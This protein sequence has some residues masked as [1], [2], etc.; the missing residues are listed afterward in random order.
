MYLSKLT[1]N[2]R[3]RTVR[4]DLADCHA[5][6]RMLLHA[7]GALPEGM[8]EA[9]AHFGLLYRVEPGRGQTA[10][11]L[12]QSDALPTWTNL[13]RWSGAC[14]ATT[15]KPLDPLY[16]GIMAGQTLV[17]RL[18]ANPTRKVETKSAADGTKCNGRRKI[19]ATEDA[20]IEWLHRK[21]K[22]GDG[23]GQCGFDLLTVRTNPGVTDVRTV[24]GDRVHG[25]WR[26]NDPKNPWGLVFG[27]V[28]FE[29]RLR[30]TD[31]DAFRAA[32]RGGIGSGKAYGFG[33]LSVAP[34][35]AAPTVRDD[36]M[37]A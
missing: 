37:T 29:G 32:L 7:F 24:V 14:E 26:G 21:G 4:R 13:D 25:A 17:F 35:R 8:T 20:Q 31:A 22:M 30:V 2:T 3:D 36:D 6:H 11:L 10:V 16:A 34:S 5:M 27:S 9:R 23:G 19:I 1:L 12:A 15:P 28:I 33:L 18:R